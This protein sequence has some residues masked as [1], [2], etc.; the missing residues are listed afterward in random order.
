MKC[1][2]WN[3]R[4]IANSSSRLALKRLIQSNHP[5]FVFI[6]EPWMDFC[7]FP[8]NWMS[9]FDLKVFA[10]NK[11]E[12]LLPNL[13]CFC[14]SNL[15]PT[16][17]A[18]DD[19]HVTFSVSI[20][21]KVVNISAVYASTCYTARRILWNNLNNLIINSKTP[22][23]FL[24]D[25][26]AIISADEYKGNHTPSNTPMHEF[27]QWSD[28]NHLIHLPTVGNM[29]T[30][31]NGRK[32]R[33]LTEK[34]LDR[35]ICNLD[36]MD[37]CNTIVC[38]TLTRVKSDHYPIFFTCKWDNISYKSQFKFLRMWTLSNDCEKVIK[39]V[40]NTKV[41]GCPMYVLDKKLRILKCKL[42]EWNKVSFGD[43]KIKVRN[44]ENSLNDIQQNIS[45]SGYSERLQIDEVKAQH[46]LEKA[47]CME[48]AF[49]KEKANLNWHI[50]GD[51]N[52][53]FFHTY[54]KIKRKNNL[55]SSLIVDDSVTT[56]HNIIEN[57]LVNHF[58]NLF[59]QNAQLQDN[60]LIHRVIPSLVNENTNTLLTITPSAD[61]IYNAVKSLKTDSA[62]GPDGFGAFF[63]QHFWH[64][65]KNDVIGAVT[66]FFLQDWILPNYNANTIILIPKTNEPNSLNH[67]RPI[68]LANFKQK[69]IS[70]IIA[71]RLAAILPSL[72]SKEQKGFVIGR[73]IKD[74]I[75]LTSEAI[76]ILNN[77]S[78]SG[79]VALKI[80]IS[81]AFDTLSWDF[82]LKTLKCF[83]FCSKFCSWIR[84]LLH[85]AMLSIGF[86][87]KQA[88]YFQCSNGVRQGD[89]LS[90]LLF[91]LAEE[92]L[93]R[94]IS[95][96][97]ENNLINL[98]KAT[99]TAFVPS[100][101]LYA[102]DIMIFCR[103]DIKSITAIAKLLNDY[104][105][106]SGQICNTSKSLIYAGGM[107]QTRFKFLADLIGFK[108]AFP[109]FLYL[110]APIFIGRA[111]PTYFL[112]V[113]DRIKLKLAS[114]KSSLLS[115]A[116][117]LQLV[118]AVIQSMVLHSIAI[119]NWPGSLIKKI[120][121]WMRNFIWSGDMEKKKLVTV[122]WKHCC[123]RVK[124]GGLGLRSLAD[125]NSASN[126]LLCWNFVEG[127]QCW[128][129]LLASRVKRGN[130]FISYHIKSSI[131]SS[132][133]D[134]HKHV[135]EN[136]KWILG[137]GSK[138]NFWL[139][140]WLDEP[141]ASVYKIPE[142]FHNQ[143]SV[144]VKD[145][146]VNGSWCIPLNVQTA[147]PTLMPLV[148]NLSL[149]RTDM[150][151]FVIWKGTDC[152]GLSMKVAYD[153][154]HKLRCSSPWPYDSFPWD[155]RVPPS[156]SL[157]VWR[158]MH[159]R[160]PTDENMSIRGFSYTSMCSLCKENVETTDHIFFNC[161]FSL[162]LW[163]WL[164][165]KL[166]YAGSICS[167]TD[168]LNLLS[169]PWSPQ[170]RV[171]VLS[172]ICSLFYQVWRARNTMR[173][174]GK[175]LHWKFC[176]GS[177]VS[178][179]KLAGDNSG[180]CSNNSIESFRILKAFNI[181]IIPSRPSI[182]M[183]VIWHPPPKGWIKINVDGLA[184]GNP[185]LSACGGIFRDENACHVGSFSDF[186]GE[187]SAFFAELMAAILAIDKARVLGW[188]KLW[189]ETDCSSVVKA[190][191]DSSLVP[192]KI[193]SRWL[194]CVAYTRNI[195]FMISHVYRE[196][197]FCADFLANLGL[198]NSSYN[199]YNYVHSILIKDYLLDM[200]DICDLPPE[201][202]V[203]IA[204][205]LVP[206]TSSVSMAP[207]RISTSELSEQ[208][209][210]LEKLLENKFVRP[211]VSPWDAPVLLVKKKDDSMRFCVDYRKLN[212]VIIKNMYPIPRIDDLMD[213]FVGACVLSN[214]DLSSGY[215]HFRVKQYDV[216]K[217][218]FRTR[219][220]HYEY[221]IMSFG[222]SNTSRVFME[223]MNKIF[224]SYLDKFVVV[225]FLNHVIS[226]GGI[227]VD[228]SKV[229]V[230][231]Q[232]ET[233]KSVTKIKSFLGLA[234]YYQRFIKAYIW[235][236]KCEESFRELKKKLTTEP[237]LILPSPSESFVVYCDASNMGLGGVL[238]QKGQVVAYA[239]P[240]LKVHER[241]YP[242]HN[243]ELA[244]VD[245]DF[246]LSYPPGKANVI[247]DALSR[248]S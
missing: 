173:F 240:Q 228:L 168:C 111:K 108:M 44:A 93:S 167:I 128:S 104:A 186:L 79:N 16:I 116:G 8:Q 51:R 157:L 19:Q 66:Q 148:S 114:W 7:N 237:M 135:M 139:D 25:F 11:R 54:A 140:L 91:C 177:I 47:L 214:I 152:G 190:F 4:G 142:M 6:A 33:H 244:T 225:G 187:G 132:I 80:D 94:G 10:F 48:E 216:P 63:F 164:I 200:E 102:D 119:Y 163:H 37:T 166:N 145:W 154:C 68:A 211:S 105:S 43:V 194:F 234:S 28:S 30:W 215:H 38:H 180:C 42:K 202:E 112:F 21:S 15:N 138:I 197:N 97:V 60:G 134:S 219:Y 227:A 141:L 242:T 87:G 147:Y 78:F 26:N 124:E 169:C 89:P 46:E 18:V 110:G 121:S 74:C 22:W 88:G 248:K 189:M 69:I 67:Y 241:N 181:G 233:P 222:V 171:V 239:S 179:A 85:S 41:Y 207:Y 235:D 20:N 52:T 232:W 100:H 185:S 183:D 229:D 58:S 39:E 212:K 176:I 126:L 5:D 118:K 151:D 213:Q 9:R 65:V 27:F 184:R 230:M 95:N 53:K 101:T 226:S 210:Q 32:G 203:E 17:L 57:H 245:Y 174:D 31:S 182:L 40:W 84:T 34:R 73:N 120:T 133:K 98:I 70:K 71:D 238:M 221:T 131:W 123:N 175:S 196:A 247:A 24:G 243:L 150:E 3:I 149:P 136:S 223:Y 90:P 224:H 83:G 192:W 103:G 198:S 59:N 72:I 76:N 159:N 193:R 201:C 29:F 12:G 35:V 122:A 172:C 209:K 178:R 45:I 56:D 107:T 77:K 82:L 162:E 146:L 2:F 23:T 130:N 137:D 161:K 92:V 61:E 204:I 106:C 64:I 49:W 99:K 220:G 117:R 208:K 81:K 218:V 75:C 246:S 199:W 231:L 217:T 115:I 129:S 125:I 55:I 50:D 13:W 153:F 191:S 14:K 158:V 62:P 96:L 113:V 195:D 160:L 155:K 86:N 143:L 156:H 1:L 188:K 36:M 206:G 170:A 144:M 165:D 109:P 205:D 127:K 236:V